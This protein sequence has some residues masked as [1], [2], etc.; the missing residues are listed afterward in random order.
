[1]KIT[2]KNLER[3]AK[4][5]YYDPEGIGIAIL[6]ALGYKVEKYM[7]SGAVAVYKNGK[8]VFWYGGVDV[9]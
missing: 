1:M 2:K 4:N 9:D 8:I 7:L 6:R 3:L 5:T